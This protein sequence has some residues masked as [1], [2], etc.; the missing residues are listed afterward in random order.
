MEQF[1]KQLARYERVLDF[2]FI[3]SVIGFVFM[4]GVLLSITFN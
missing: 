4:L 2:V 1:E 3:F